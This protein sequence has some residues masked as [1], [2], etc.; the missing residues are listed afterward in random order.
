[1][2]QGFTGDQR[3]FLAYAQSWASKMRDADAAP[4]NRHRRPCA[5]PVPRADR[6][7]P[8]RVVCRVQRAAGPETVPATR[9]ARAHLVLRRSRQMAVPV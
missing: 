9:P 6:A 2:I 1:M 3:F 5:R 8:R 7:Q 4:A